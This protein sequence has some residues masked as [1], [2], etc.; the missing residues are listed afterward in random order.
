MHCNVM[1]R[2]MEQSSSN[3]YKRWNLN[4]LKIYI[5]KLAFYV[6]INQNIRTYSYFSAPM[7]SLSRVIATS[8]ALWSIGKLTQYNCIYLFTYLFSYQ[9]YVRLTL[10]HEIV[11]SENLH[12]AVFFHL[13]Q[14]NT[15]FRDL[16]IKIFSFVL[17]ENQQNKAKI[18]F[19]LVGSIPR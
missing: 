19:L 13:K 14:V 1:P 2:A 18:L 16:F 6:I 12:C 3:C 17:W 7:N 10:P 8:I 15:I 9:T 11:W 4:W 5:F